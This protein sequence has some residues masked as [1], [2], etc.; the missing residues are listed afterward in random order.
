MRRHDRRDARQDRRHVRRD[1]N[2]NGSTARHNRHDGRE[3]RRHDR[4]HNRQ[5]AR[6]YYRNNYYGG[7]NYYGRHNHSSFGFNLG[8]GSYGYGNRFGY[9]YY[10][11]YDLYPWWYGD[12]Y[13]Y[14][15]Q[16]SYRTGY[17]HR[18]HSNIYCTDPNHQSY[19]VN[20]SNGYQNQYAFSQYTDGTYGGMNVRDCHR[21]NN[22]GVFG[23]RSA[24]VSSMVCYDSANAEYYETG[25]KTLIRYIN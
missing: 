5:V 13:G 15:S 17:G 24:V 20:W 22:R 2:H 3:V 12:R 18:G 7:R 21:E 11:N 19:G 4:R 9:P 1:A 23:R 6:N 14:R 16:T 25:A 8:Y 10:S